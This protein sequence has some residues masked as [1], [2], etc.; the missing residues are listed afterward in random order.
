MF[1]LYPDS[2]KSP[3]HLGN[4][5][6]QKHYL[7]NI[8]RNVNQ[9]IYIYTYISY[10]QYFLSVVLFP[11]YFIVFKHYYDGHLGLEWVKEFSWYSKLEWVKKTSNTL[12]ELSQTTGGSL[13]GLINH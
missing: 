1:H 13:A 6:N 10:V 3:D 12:L 8:F 7:K 5:F 11:N 2:P 9:Y 4:P